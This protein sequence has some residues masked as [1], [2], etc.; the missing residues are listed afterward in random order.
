MSDIYED[1]AMNDTGITTYASGD[2]NRSR[3]EM[4]ACLRRTTIPEDQVLSNLG[5]FL[6]S[7]NLARILFMDHLYRQIVDVQGCV[8]EFGCRWGQN[9]GLFSALRGIYE[10]FNRHRQIVGFDTFV[11]FPG[12]A[13]Q[14]GGAS[15]MREGNLA[16][17]PGYRQE[18]ETVLDLHERLNPL[19]HIRKFE[20]VAGDAC[21]EL[22]RYLERAPHTVIALAYFDFDLYEPTLACLDLIKD[23]L[24]KGSVLGFDELN[25][26]DSPG[27][28]LALMKAFGLRNVR[29]KRF[30]H[31][32][33]V[34]Y[35]VV[36]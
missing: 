6:E 10:P 2:E 19:P 36:E 26:P 14:D 27:E 17:T 20:L 18:L 29:L 25:D 16:T 9:L 1:T 33:R 11:G 30:P 28:T 32:S 12:I 8:M 3:D 22:P 34:S 15:L 5:L 21:T 35:F 24:V 13:D 31:A 4:A 23:R 7:K